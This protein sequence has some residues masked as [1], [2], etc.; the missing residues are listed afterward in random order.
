[1]FQC[2]TPQAIVLGQ[3]DDFEDGTRQGWR[4]GSSSITSSHM[5]NIIS[6]GPAGAG[7]NYLQISSDGTVNA[8]GRL[9]FFNTLQWTGDFSAIG[10]TSIA[11]DLKNFGATGSEPLV[12]RLAI[13]GGFTDPNN[14]GNV[15]GGLFATSASVS[16][17][18]GSGWIHAVFS[19]NP[20]DLVPVSGKVGLTGNDVLASLGNVKQLRILNSSTAD[21]SGQPAIAML[22]I[23]NI[24][25]GVPLPPALLL[26]SSGFMC[27]LVFCGVVRDYLQSVI[28]LVNALAVFISRICKQ[29]RHKLYVFSY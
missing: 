9:T 12:I 14:L 18:G 27:L 2:G 1:M 17:I 10:I 26:F 11:M 7:D 8:G 24:T 21:W 29:S 13:N 3:V 22:G 15:I 25:A 4:M 5:T 16:P 28:N 23:D 20:D 6:G 19:L